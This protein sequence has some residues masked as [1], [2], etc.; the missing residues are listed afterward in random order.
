M[1]VVIRGGFFWLFGASVILG[2]VGLVKL[3]LK[4][5]RTLKRKSYPKNVVILHQF[6]PGAKIPSLS[7][8][9][10]KLETWYV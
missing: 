3:Y 4:R 5:K 9:C 6:P 7:P 10:L 1:K 8:F 2:S